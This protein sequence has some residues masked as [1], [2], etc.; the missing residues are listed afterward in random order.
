[1]VSRQRVRGICS[2]VAVAAKTTTF[3]IYQST[4]SG[5]TL[6]AGQVE[7]V[8]QIRA[9]DADPDSYQF[10]DTEARFKMVEGCYCSVLDECWIT[11]FKVR[12]RIVQACEP[13]PDNQRW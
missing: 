7:S 4:A 2:T 8:L 6:P 1:M 10:L 11:D 9:A 12:P 3:S 5:M 13:I